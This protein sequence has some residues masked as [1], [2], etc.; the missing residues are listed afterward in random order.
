MFQS[1]KHSKS[2]VSFAVQ[3]LVITKLMSKG[4]VTLMC[5]DGTNDVGALKH[6]HCGKSAPS[7]WRRHRNVTIEHRLANL[8]L[9]V[10]SSSFF[11][12]FVL[13]SFMLT[14]PSSKP[15]QSLEVLQYV[16]I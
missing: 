13:Y 9:F 8:L 2:C 3:E 15:R 5:G 7:W 10:L 4:F 16:S 1:W 6:A 12:P 14:V 11:C